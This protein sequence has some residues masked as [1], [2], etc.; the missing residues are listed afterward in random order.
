MQKILIIGVGGIGSNL[1]PL[2]CKVGQYDITI[3]DPDTVEEKNIS[4][5]NFNEQNIGNYK[6][7]ESREDFKT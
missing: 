4:S 2:L 7:A 3:A 5:Q 6:C 1:V